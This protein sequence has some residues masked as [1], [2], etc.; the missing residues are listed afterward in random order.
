[1]ICVGGGVCGFVGGWVLSCYMLFEISGYSVGL[2]VSWVICWMS[3]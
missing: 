1:M 2:I 3:E